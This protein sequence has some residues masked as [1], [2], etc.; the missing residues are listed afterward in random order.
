MSSVSTYS[1]PAV[2]STPELFDGQ[3]QAFDARAGFPPD[4]CSAI[5]EAVLESADVGP[6]ELILEVGAGTGQIGLWLATSRRYVGVDFSSGML[7]RFRARSSESARCPLVRADANAAWP[8]AHGVARAIFSSRTLHLLSADHVAEEALRVA[9]RSGATLIIGRVERSRQSLRAQMASEMRRRLRRAGFAP[10]RDQQHWRLIDACLQRG[11]QQLAPVT[12]TRWMVNTS[13]R[14]SLDAWR[15][16]PGLGGIE[17][18]EE[19]R[20]AVLRELEA[21]AEQHFG[22][23]DRAFESEELYVLKRLYLVPE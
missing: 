22:R 14:E 16:L 1:L 10:R 7:E 19:C 4:R 13:A 12:A 23:L 6:D 17:V 20:H 3:A 8:F 21:W 2:T 11:A 15:R 18:A 9:C 5:A